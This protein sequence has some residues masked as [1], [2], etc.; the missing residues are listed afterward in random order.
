MDEQVP[1]YVDRDKS[2]IISRYR[3][4]SDAVAV[5]THKEHFKR[6]KTQPFRREIRFSCSNYRMTQNLKD[7]FEI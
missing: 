3:I 5:A 4:N 7:H 6:K 2:I 1:E